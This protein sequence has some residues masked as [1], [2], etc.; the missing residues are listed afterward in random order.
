MATGNFVAPVWLTPPLT[1]DQFLPNAPATPGN[2][3]V[4]LCGGGS[5]ALTAGMGELQALAYLTARNGASLLS[6]VKALSTVSGGSWLGVP[7]CYLP[8]SGP[9][10]AAYLGTHNTNQGSLTVAQLGQ[11]PAGNAGVPLTS[12]FFSLELIALQAYLLYEFDNVPANMLWQTAI[13]LNL[14]SPYSLFSPGQDSAPTDMFSYD[15][16]TLAAEVTGPNPSLATETAYLYADAVGTG[17]ARRPYLI[18]NMAMFLAEPGTDV[19]ALAPVQATPFL[20]GITGAPAGTDANGLTPGGGGVGS[21]AF[22]SIYVAPGTSSATVAQTRQW[23]ITDIVGTSSAA[24]A[25]ELQ[26]QIAQWLANPAE[27]GK[28]LLQYAQEILAW[29]EKHLE[30]A[31]Q[32]KAK[33]FVRTL[34]TAAGADDMAVLK[35]SFTGLQDLIPAYY[36]WPATNPAVIGQPQP[37]RFADGGN[38]ENTGVNGLLA[39]GDIDNIISFINCEIPMTAGGPGVADGNGGFI[40]GTSIIVDDQLPPLFGYQPYDATSGYVPY[41]GASNPSNPMFAQSQVFACSEFPALLQGLWAASGAGAD[42]APAV[43]KQQLAV[44]NNPWFGV[45]GGK[46]VTVVWCYLSLVTAWTAQFSNNAAVQNLIASE[47]ANAQFPHYSTFQ[48]SLSATEIN[49]MTNLTSWTVVTADEASQ[50]FSSLFA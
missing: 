47:V 16:Q 46:T 40:P 7:Y 35:F 22:N 27:L 3:G 4:C 32:A 25:E 6:Q 12:S 48:T 26:N 30:L 33:A 38:L 43:F 24:F 37:T 11:L 10:D 2:V 42:S 17:R 28:L 44:M 41:A 5:R 39:Y 45:A 15:A 23:A 14:L 8:A 18:C 13:A 36:Y 9:A 49:L 29:I 34:M 31:A 19:Q 50:V 21:F 1:V 20:T